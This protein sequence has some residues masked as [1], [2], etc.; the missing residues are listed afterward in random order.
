[1]QI[2]PALE[3]SIKNGGGLLALYF[4]GLIAMVLTFPSDKRKKLFYEPSYP[5]ADWRWSVLL[6]GRVA[7]VSF[8]V[9]MFFTPLKIGAPL[10]YI[11]LLVYG[12]GYFI[13]MVA[14]ITY[15]QAPRN[16]IVGAG[17]YRISRNPQWVGLVFVFIGSV[18]T[19]AVWLHLILVLLL[20]GAYHF[21]ILLEEGSC[22]NL[23]GER[24]QDYMRRVPRYFLV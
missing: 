8:V 20:V 22:L 17:L 4:I 6:V 14:L 21:Q 2:L 18:M 1:M 19:V 16:Q 15:R 5:R 24:Y 11:G 3:F 7:A 9:L 10:F 23:Y 12:L 13:V